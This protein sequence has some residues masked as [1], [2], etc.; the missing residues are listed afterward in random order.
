MEIKVVTFPDAGH[1]KDKKAKRPFWENLLGGLEQGARAICNDEITSFG[2]F[3]FV[4][5]GMEKHLQ[6]LGTAGFPAVRRWA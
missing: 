4:F 2:S 1:L 6:T 5:G 3:A